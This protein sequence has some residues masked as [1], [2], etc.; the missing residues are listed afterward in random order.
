[1]AP[2]IGAVAPG[3]APPPPVGGVAGTPDSGTAAATEDPDFPGGTIVTGPVTEVDAEFVV[4]NLGGDRLGVVSRRHWDEAPPEDLTT[5]VQPGDM[6]LGAV[7]IRDDPKGRVVLS[8]SWAVRKSA[9]DALAKAKEEKD[10]VE[11]KVVKTVKGGLVLDVGIRGF[12]PR[13]LATLDPSEKLG[14]LVGETVTVRVLEL[15]TNKNRVVLDRKTVLRKERGSRRAEVMAGLKKNEVREGTVRSIADFGV[16]VDIGG[17]EGLVHLSELSWTRVE[18]AASMVSVGQKVTVKVLEVRRSKGRI[19][20]SMRAATPDPIDVAQKDS[21]V[22]GTV[23]RL[24]DFGAFV[25]IGGVEGLVHINQLSEHR[26][27]TPDEVV[28]PG[29]R[30]FVKVIGVD[31]KRRRVDLSITQAVQSVSAPPVDPAAKVIE[32]APPVSEPAPPEPEPSAEQ[33]QPDPEAP[34][35]DAEAPPSDEPAAP[36]TVSEEPA[37][38]EATPEA[39]APE[40]VAPQEPASEE[41]VADSVAAQ[42]HESPGNDASGESPS[43]EATVPS[44]AAEPA[45]PAG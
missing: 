1:M 42:D 9:M 22:E 18:D 33:A 41:P 27:F 25:D 24:A 36:E 40:A 7:L 45:D 13:S 23:T 28:I 2:E 12:L 43:A 39:V 37:P 26:V 29:D 34:A 21:V 5:V 19:R 31:R 35:D 17:A 44:E 4:V 38:E 10:T 8:R 6:V 11:A 14:D 16:F 20:L 15:D 3:G 32:S 30:V